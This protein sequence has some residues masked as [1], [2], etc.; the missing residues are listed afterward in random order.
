VSP[1]QG[2]DQCQGIRETCSPVAWP[3]DRQLQLQALPVLTLTPHLHKYPLL[4]LKKKENPHS[5]QIKVVIC[6]CL[7]RH[8]DKEK[9]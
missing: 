3:E 9:E 2:M 5:L 7:A 1:G 4:V 8:L 6:F